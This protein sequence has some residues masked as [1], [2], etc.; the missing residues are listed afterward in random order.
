[1]KIPW[2]LLGFSSR[3][4]LTENP[5]Y[6]VSDDSYMKTL[7]YKP[8]LLEAKKNVLPSNILGK[9]HLALHFYRKK[10]LSCSPGWKNILA[11][12]ESDMFLTVFLPCGVYEFFCG[13][14]L[15]S[16]AFVRCCGHPND[17]PPLYVYKMK[18]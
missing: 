18:I 10:Y 16:N 3:L 15:S 2:P 1:V 12:S 11:Q 7:S 4:P 6:Y 9:K 5:G 13:D 14:A 8:L 17:P